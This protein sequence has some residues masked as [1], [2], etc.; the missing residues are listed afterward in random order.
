MKKTLFL[1]VMPIVAVVSAGLSRAA[2]SAPVPDAFRGN[3]I[4]TTTNLWALSLWNDFAVIDASF[5]D[6]AKWR[7]AGERAHAV[8]TRA[9]GEK[10]DLRFE[11]LNDSMLIMRE[12]KA[13]SILLRESVTTAGRPFT[14][15]GRD[16]SSFRSAPWVNDSI[17]VEGFITGYKPGDAV[18][19]YWSAELFG[20]A[21]PNTPMNT[22]RWAVSGPPFPLPTTNCT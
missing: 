2:A 1:L 3:W 21:A 10:R 9:D 5:W 11:L 13:R 7:G 4:D 20:F 16:T 12:G 18:Y 6:Y 22:A 19:H 17:Y 14:A 15:A 8:L